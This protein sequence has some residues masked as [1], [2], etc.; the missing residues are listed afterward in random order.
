MQE[1][2]RILEYCSAGI[3]ADVFMVH[4]HTALNQGRVLVPGQ[5][6]LGKKLQLEVQGE[7]PFPED[8]RGLPP[9]HADARQ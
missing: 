9:P 5:I 8:C 6:R 7:I 4:E 2:G 1:P 3:N